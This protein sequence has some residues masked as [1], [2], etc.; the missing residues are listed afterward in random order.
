MEGFIKHYLTSSTLN[1][2]ASRVHIT[3]SMLNFA[4]VCLECKLFGKCQ[5]FAL[6]LAILHIDIYITWIM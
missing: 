1:P 6:I 3:T 5:T 4:G 2:S